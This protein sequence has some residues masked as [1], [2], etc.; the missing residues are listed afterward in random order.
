MSALSRWYFEKIATWAM[1]FRKP[2]IAHDYWQ[3]VLDESPDDTGVLAMRAHQ[4]AAEG[5]SSAAITQFERVLQ[6]KPQDMSSWFNLGF[7]LQKENA[8]EKAIQA[9]NETLRLDEKL[10]RAWFGKGLSH[11]VLTQY[12]EAIKCFKKTNQLQPM[13]PHGFYELAVVQHRVQDLNGCEKTMRKVKEFDPK[14]AA[15]LEDETGIKIGIDRWWVR[16]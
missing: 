6:L 2:E 11:K 1:V 16:R 3:R 10:D 14:V 15:Q 8:H 5:K 13:S 12:D 4:L 9:F 7:L